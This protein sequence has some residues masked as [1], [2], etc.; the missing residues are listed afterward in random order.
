M[1][2]ILLAEDDECTRR[3]MNHRLTMRG[4]EVD[5][6]VNGQEALDVAPNGNYDVIL[7]DMHMPIMDGYEATRQLRESG[8]TGLIVAVTASV[9]DPDREKALKAGCNEFIP[10]PI[11]SSFEGIVAEMIEK[12]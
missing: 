1:S 11:S 7:M 2:R 12:F 4:H 9:M 3:M 5:Y 8:Y 10:K 6:A